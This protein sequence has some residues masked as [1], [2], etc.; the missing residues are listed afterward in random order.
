MAGFIVDIT[1]RYGNVTYEWGNR[2]IV[3]AADLTDASSVAAILVTG[4]KVIHSS[5]VEFIQAR[6][7]TVAANDG[8]YITLPLTGFGEQVPD[9][10]PLPAITTVNVEVQ[11]AGFGRPGRKF[12]HPFLDPSYMSTVKEFSWL[13]GYLT[14]VFDAVIQMI[15]DA[16]DNGTPIVRDPDH[17]WLEAIAVQRLFGYHQFTK[18]SPRPAP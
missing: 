9:G 2:Y 14:T 15:S 1:K 18:Q 13:D 10:L 16:N 11:I 17:E 4:E 8:N 6:V 3:N 7:A 12:Y 5:F